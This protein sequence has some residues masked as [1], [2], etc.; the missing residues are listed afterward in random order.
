MIVGVAE[1]FTYNKRQTNLEPM[2]ES[3]FVPLSA[4]LLAGTKTEKAPS[5]R[6]FLRAIL[7]TF[8]GAQLD[9]L[10]RSIVH[11]KTLIAEAAELSGAAIIV[12][13]HC[14]PNLSS[15]R[16]LAEFD[17][18][19]PDNMRAGGLDAGGERSRPCRESTACL[20]SNPAVPSVPPRRSVAPPGGPGPEISQV[21]QSQA[22]TILVESR[23]RRWE[24]SDVA[25]A[26]GFRPD[27]KKRDKA[28]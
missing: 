27:P 3:R 5:R 8:A 26:G 14:H 16:S 1:F 18:E 17:S 4:T 15:G 24:L 7:A 21:F 25:Y 2:F 13:L 10:V 12:D 28:S 6:V 11:D 22:P 9:P 20:G 19:I 23:I